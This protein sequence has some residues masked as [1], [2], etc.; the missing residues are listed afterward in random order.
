MARSYFQRVCPDTISS[1]TLKGLHYGTN[2]KLAEW[3]GH[4]H[5][6]APDGVSRVYSVNYW[7]GAKGRNRIKINTVMLHPESYSCETVSQAAGRNGEKV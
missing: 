6:T 1:D 5:H 3:N 2:T 7:E 4:K